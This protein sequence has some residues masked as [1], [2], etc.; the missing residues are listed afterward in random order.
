[1]MHRTSS[2]DIGHI[3]NNNNVKN[4]GKKNKVRL[5]KNKKKHSMRQHDNISLLQE[6]YERI[7][8]S[9]VKL[10]KDLP[11]SEPTLKGLNACNYMELTDIQRESI[12]LSLRG[13][14]ILGAAKTGSGKT[15][16][17]LVPL[18]ERLYIKQWDRCAGIGALVITPTRELAYQ[19]FE[20]LKLVGTH[21]DF[22]AALLIGGKDL[23]FEKTRIHKCNILICTPGR[24][25]Q[26]MEENPQFDCSYIQILV[27]DEA[28]RILD[29]GFQTTVDSI[30]ENLPATRQTLLFSA[31]QTKSQNMIYCYNVFPKRQDMISCYDVSPKRREM[32]TCLINTRSVR[33]LA[34]LSLQDP[35]YVS[36]H[37]HAR[38]STPEGLQQSYVVC[39]LEEKLSVLWSF[40]KMHLK[41]KILVFM[42]TC[43]QVKYHYD[44]FCRLRPGTTLLA[45]YGSLHQLRRMA[46]Y[47]SFCRKSNAV[48]FATDIAARGLGRN[49]DTSI[50]PSSAVELNTTSALANYATEAGGRPCNDPHF[51]FLCVTDFPAV[52]WV[53]QLDCPEDAHTYI[54]RVGR[55]ARYQLGGESLLVLLPSE[56]QGMVEQMSDTK[57]PITKIKINPNKLQNPVR[58]M[59]ALLARDPNLK[60]SAQRAFVTYAKSVFL[61][62]NKQV[63]NVGALDTDAYSK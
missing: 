16:A 48:L 24:L 18:L 44:M 45:L 4:K 46:I 41:Q 47:E 25:L 22:S 53:V 60:A 6:A 17:F 40:I 9:S 57:I 14:D 11:L 43:K 52:D 34:R 31:T 30:L 29:L 54:H 49:W 19:I 62:K 2:E 7:N 42:A 5:F 37:E 28:D 12:G 15:L 23:K 36:V 39:A 35:M 3:N 56:E 38:H 21:H 50:S 1:M 20:T 13:C 33:D 26:H 55:T 51:Y 58:K 10:F 63:F 27:L 8:I 32:I 59:E 61:M